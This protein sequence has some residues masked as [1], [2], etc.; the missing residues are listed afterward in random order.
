[1]TAG[2]LLRGARRRHGLTQQQLADRARTSQAAISRIERDL[3]SPS[4]ESLA[5]ILDR[6]GEELVLTTRKIDYEHNVS[7]L[8]ENLELSPAERIDQGALVGRL[9]QGDSILNFPS[10]PTL[11]LEI[12]RILDKRGNGW[13]TT[14]DIADAVNEAQRYRKETTSSPVTPFQIHGRT[15]NYD[16]VFERKGSHVRLRRTSPPCARRR[17]RPADAAARGV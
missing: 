10:R 6:M 8:R 16:E 2:E 13:M 3:V 12:A 14:R 4:V 11:H 1:V 17:G 9:L 5:Q 7:V 15:K